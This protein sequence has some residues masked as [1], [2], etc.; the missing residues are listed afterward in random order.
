MFPSRTLVESQVPA[1]TKILSKHPVSNLI[2][3]FL[4]RVG[5]RIPQ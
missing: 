2:T 4:T 5:F 1:N 3:K